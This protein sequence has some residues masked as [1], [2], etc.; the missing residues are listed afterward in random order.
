MQAQQAGLST[1]FQEFNLLPERTVAENIYL[2]REPR[3][4]GLVDD[5]RC[6]ATPRRCSTTSA[7][8]GSAHGSGCAA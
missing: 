4:L 5:R 8:P 1:V 6:T 7:S 3:R 2:G